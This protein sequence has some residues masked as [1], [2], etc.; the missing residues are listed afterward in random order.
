MSHFLTRAIPDFLHNCSFYFCVLS[1]SPSN[2]GRSCAAAVVLLLLSFRT[3]YG[4]RGLL[5]A[6]VTPETRVF[7]LLV[8]MWTLWQRSPWHSSVMHALLM[9]RRRKVNTAVSHRKK[10]LFV[11]APIT[12]VRS[13]ARYDSIHSTHSR[14][15]ERWDSVR[16]EE[17][18]FLWRHP[19]IEALNDVR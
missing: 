5:L 4:Q 19:Y 17:C 15:S 1:H 7:S 11:F 18:C 9:T 8:G 10:T 6:I 14:C 2:Y 3:L 16:N 12:L 13:F